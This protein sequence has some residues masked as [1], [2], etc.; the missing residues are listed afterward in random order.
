MAGDGLDFFDF[1]QNLVDANSRVTIVSL[2]VTTPQSFH[3]TSHWGGID[4]HM[5]PLGPGKPRETMDG[6][7][8]KMQSMKSKP[9]HTEYQVMMTFII[10]KRYCLHTHML[11]IIIRFN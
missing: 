7:C 6:F 10:S 9:L 2:S 3:L 8:D 5:L 11:R 1:E 4:T